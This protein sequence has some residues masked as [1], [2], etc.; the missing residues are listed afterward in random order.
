MFRL[1]ILQVIVRY[2]I[3]VQS[4][5]N[6][7]EF[8]YSKPNKEML[9]FLPI[10]PNLPHQ[11]FFISYLHF[12]PQAWSLG[13]ELELHFEKQDSS[14]LGR[15][16]INKKEGKS[17]ECFF[18]LLKPINHT[19][20]WPIWSLCFSLEIICPN[21]IMCLNSYLV[22]TFQTE[23]LFPKRGIETVFSA[24]LN[25][26]T[27]EG[28]SFLCDHHDFFPPPLSLDCDFLSNSILT[29]IHSQHVSVPL[30]NCPP[31]PVFIWSKLCK[32]LDCGE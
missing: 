24:L 2:V 32:P 20:P 11:H 17:S 5:G 28:R 8:Q 18:F 30:P 4:Y 26:H 19:D 25:R 10:F 31:R 7:I 13:L 29:S 27:P 9:C 6:K 22:L 12:H 15:S 14:Q 23:Q 3:F 21:E 16:A 1:N